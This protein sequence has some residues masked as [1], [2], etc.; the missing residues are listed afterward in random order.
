MTCYRG[1]LPQTSSELSRLS[2]NLLVEVYG[3]AK[4]WHKLKIPLVFT[5][6]KSARVCDLL[7]LSSQ[8]IDIISD[9]LFSSKFLS[10][11]FERCQITGYHE[12]YP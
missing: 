11:I 8:W 4:F 1:Y 10:F 12:T 6:G 7:S 5:T 2:Q 9:A 3:T